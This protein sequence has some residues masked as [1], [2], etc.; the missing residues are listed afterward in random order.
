[1][2]GML[3]SSHGVQWIKSQDLRR[4]HASRASWG[5]KLELFVLLY[6]SHMKTFVPSQGDSV[7]LDAGPSLHQTLT[8]LP[9][10]WTSTLQKR[11]FFV[12]YSSS[13]ISSYQ[14]ETKHSWLPCRNSNINSFFSI[15]A[16]QTPCPL[17]IVSFQFGWPMF[18]Y[19]S[20]TDLL[21]KMMLTN[22]K[23]IL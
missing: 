11:L 6:L 8:C 15:L 13:N 14:E 9:D 23:S 19:Q 21:P 12:I 5:K 22:S 17:A 20:F 16:I 18:S 7:S 1:M 2:V 10:S 3:M 4:L